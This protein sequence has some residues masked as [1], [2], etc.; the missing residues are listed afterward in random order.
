M[1]PPARERTCSAIASRS[2]TC[3]AT[4]PPPSSTPRTAGPVR[5]PD[6]EREGRFLV[7]FAAVHLDLGNPGSA[8]NTLLAAERRALGE[9]QTCRLAC[10]N[11]VSALT[12][13]S[14]AGDGGQLAPILGVRTVAQLK[15]RCCGGL[16][17]EP[18]PSRHMATW[19]RC[20]KGHI[21]CRSGSLRTPRSSASGRCGQASRQRRT[22]PDLGFGCGTQWLSRVRLDRTASAY[23]AAL[24]VE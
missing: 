7:D 5:F 13:R 24:R 11:V 6:V 10:V 1:P 19:A 22:C 17:W 12:G 2:S 21:R 18:M 20:D 8:Y 16:Y 15:Q 4:R 3:W 9:V 14:G 23:G